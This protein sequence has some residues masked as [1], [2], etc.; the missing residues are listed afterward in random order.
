MGGCFLASA[1]EADLGGASSTFAFLLTF[2]D[3]VQHRTSQLNNLRRNDGTVNAAGHGTSYTP[4]FPS[5]MTVGQSLDAREFQRATFQ[6][7]VAS[8]HA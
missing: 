1:I 5:E 4:A 7:Q 2:L 8:L 6:V 3:R